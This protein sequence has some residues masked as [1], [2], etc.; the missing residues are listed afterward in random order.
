MMTRLETRTKE[1][2]VYARYCQIFIG[3]AE[4]KANQL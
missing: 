4:A 1:F 3:M 2:N